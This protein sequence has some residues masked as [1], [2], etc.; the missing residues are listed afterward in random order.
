MQQTRQIGTGMGVEF[1]SKP[2][3]Y[4]FDIKGRAE[5]IR[6]ALH[7]GGIEFEDVR[8]DQASFAQMKGQ[9]MFAFGQLP[10]LEVDGKRM[11]QS[12]AILGWAGHYAKLNPGGSDVWREGKIWEIVNALQDCM[13]CIAT[14]IKETDTTKRTQMRENLSKTELPQCFT[15]LERLLETNKREMG[16]NGDWC[17]GNSMTTADLMLFCMHDWVSCGILDNIPTDIMNKYTNINRVVNSVKNNQ[18][19]KE[20][21]S[22]PKHTTTGVQQKMTHMQQQQMGTAQRT[23]AQ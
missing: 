10:V 16:G 14:S 19:V 18:K 1:K 12:M 15:N 13:G 20:W 3:L 11:S 7:I 23:G 22:N 9:G 4:Y 6:L 21:Y 8:L 17:C 2:K 5:A